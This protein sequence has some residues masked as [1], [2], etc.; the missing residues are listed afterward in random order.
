[1]SIFA[2]ATNYKNFSNKDIIK[3]L[4]W[5]FRYSKQ[6]IKKN[7]KELLNYDT[8]MDLLG[9]FGEIISFSEKLL[10]NR[11]LDFLKLKI[12]KPELNFCRRLDEMGVD[13]SELNFKIGKIWSG[14]SYYNLYDD[15]TI[16]TINYKELRDY[17]VTM[18]ELNAIGYELENRFFKNN[19]PKYKKL[20]IWKYILDI[21]DVVLKNTGEL[22]KK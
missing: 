10:E 18:S 5:L 21:I 16:E 3:E 14:N 7:K 6:I 17:I 8:Q 13:A 20:K 12:G 11:H 22:L 19:Q 9:I 1:M 4:S 15:K 2:G